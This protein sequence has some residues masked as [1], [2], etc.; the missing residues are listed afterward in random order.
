MLCAT[1]GDA[2]GTEN[3]RN[4]R[5]AGPLSDQGS[6]PVARGA[7]TSCQITTHGYADSI[8][9]CLRYSTLKYRVAPTHQGAAIGKP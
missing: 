3:D 2:R 5:H 9:E 1:D 8:L 7:W 4:N 6:F